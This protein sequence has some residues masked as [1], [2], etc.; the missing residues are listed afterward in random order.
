MPETCVPQTTRVLTRWRAP[1]PFKLLSPP[2]RFVV[3]TGRA[4][5]DR[6][7]PGRAPGDLT[8]PSIA[9]HGVFQE[10]TTGIGIGYV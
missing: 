10:D 8:S 2:T 3:T 9:S 1:N 6:S 4:P 7:Q 5:G